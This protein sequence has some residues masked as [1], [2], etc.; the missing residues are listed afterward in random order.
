[1]VQQAKRK[2]PS[3]FKPSNTFHKAQETVHEIERDTA[4]NSMRATDDYNRAEGINICSGNISALV[5][6]GN[7]ASRIFQETSNEII[8]SCN[9]TLSICTEISREAIVCRT[10]NDV[11]ELQ[12][13]VVQQIYENYFTTAN[14]LYEMLFSPFIK[15]SASV[16]NQIPKT[17]AA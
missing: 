1:V 9:R 14:K 17:M 11:M 12:N 5:E 3:S 7:A 4:E 15:R 6:S 2:H 10:I 8:E 13:S 16:S